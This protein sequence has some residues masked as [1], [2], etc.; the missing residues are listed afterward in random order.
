VIQA[1][2]GKKRG[3]IEINR[4]IRGFKIVFY[5]QVQ[6]IILE[7]CFLREIDLNT[8]KTKISFH[9]NYIK[10]I[11]TLLWAKF[12]FITKTNFRRV[13]KIAK[14]DNYLCRI[15]QSFCLSVCPFSRPTLRPSVCP[16]GTTRL[17]L[18]GFSWYLIFMDFAKT[19]RHNS[20]LI[21][22]WQG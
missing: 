18:D 12:I 21:K 17:P 8:M 7:R 11:F 6:I 10:T 4:S 2:T 3:N 19:C 14:G 16:R 9:N 20:S 1:V 15:S 13:R 5:K 22:M